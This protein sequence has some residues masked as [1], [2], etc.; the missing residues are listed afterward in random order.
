MKNRFK[1]L[2]WYECIHSR[3]Y[4]DLSMKRLDQ[5]LEE[6]YNIIKVANKYYNDMNHERISAVELCAGQGRN[7]HTIMKRLKPKKYTAIDYNK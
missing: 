4:D 5:I 6:F 7:I 2:C 1:N 3:E